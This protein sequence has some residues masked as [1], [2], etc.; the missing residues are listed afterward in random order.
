MHTIEVYEQK[1]N[2]NLKLFKG[3]VTNLLS[4]Y[5]NG[6]IKEQ[7]DSIYSLR[8]ER[9]EIWEQVAPRMEALIQIKNIYKQGFFNK[10]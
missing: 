10:R 5:W 8:E 7:L 3:K 6:P 2:D 1:R 4:S 9:E